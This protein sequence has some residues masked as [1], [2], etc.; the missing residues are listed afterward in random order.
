[1]SNKLALI[2][3]IGITM[4][5][6]HPQCQGIYVKDGK[7]EAVGSTETIRA[8]AEN[9]QAQLIDLQGKTFLPGLHD[10][11]VH[12]MNTGLAA[13]GIDLYPCRSIEAVVQTLKSEQTPNRE[14]WIY[15]YGLDESRLTEKRP[16]TAKEL[17]AV[18]KERPV[19]LADRGLHYTQVNTAALEAMGFSGGEDGLIKDKDGVCTGRLK[20]K[21]HGHARKFF[22]DKMTAEQRETAIRHTADLAVKAGVTTIHAMEGGDLSSDDDIPVFLKIMDSLPV[23]IVLHWCSTSIKDVTNKDLNII[24]TD[25]L[26]DGSIGSRTA[27]FEEPYADDTSTKGELYYDDDWIT[28]YIVAAHQNGLQT[29]FHVIGQRAITQ[30]L[31]CLERALDQYPVTD[32]RFR[33]EHFGFPNQRDIERAAALGAVISTQPAFT[34]LRGGPDSVYADRVGAQRNRRAYPIHDFLEAGLVVNGGSDSNVTP[35]DPLLGIHAAVNP[36]YIQNAISPY[37]A[38]RL[39]TIDGAYTAKEEKTRGS[40]IPGKAGDITVVSANPL[41]VPSDSIRDMAV[42]MTIYQGNVVYQK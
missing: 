12:M 39:F 41:T 23:H 30:V 7:I 19:Y 18:F 17:D 38:L 11:H 21:A 14:E 2:N 34:Y 13:I 3:G 24:G 16:P 40:L 5:E 26:L 33:L 37:Q 4:D 8:M 1:M 29:G 9:D 10:C 42:E 28:D 36:P 20:N 15:G 31:D 6:N 25:I 35:I 22:F 27:A 32:H